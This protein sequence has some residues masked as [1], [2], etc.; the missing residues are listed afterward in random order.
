MKYPE[1]VHPPAA[2]VDRQACPAWAVRIIAGEDERDASRGTQAQRELIAAAKRYTASQA[3]KRIR[4]ADVGRAL[5]ISPEYLTSI[6]REVEGIPFYQ[7]SLRKRLEQAVRLLPEYAS[8]LSELALELDFSSHSHFTTA[9]R[10]AFGC[11]P[12]AFR[13]RARAACRNL[14]ALAAV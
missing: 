14:V 4:L 9:F 3:G 8:G 7:Y 5:H 13:Q 11:S 12:A 2:P 10:Q 1:V 6:F